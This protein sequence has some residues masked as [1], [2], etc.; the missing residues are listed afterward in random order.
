MASPSILR[1]WTWSRCQWPLPT[2]PA[3][4]ADTADQGESI[5]QCISFAVVWGERDAVLPIAHGKAL[6]QGMEGVKFTELAGCGH[7]LHHDDP[8]SFLMVIREALD[9]VSW[10]PVRVTAAAS[11]S[12]R[13]AHEAAGSGPWSVRV[14]RPQAD[15]LVPADVAVRL[16]TPKIGA[17]LTQ[18]P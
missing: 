14:A 8:Q 10:P 18:K 15:S 11:V 3:R 12:W 13:A 9:A 7:Y 1:P 2:V 5:R 16:R 4:V 6:A 17:T